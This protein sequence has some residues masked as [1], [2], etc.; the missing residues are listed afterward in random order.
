V[1][2]VLAEGLGRID[3]Q[4][5][6]V[7]V[8]I[9][10][11][12][13]SAPVA[14]LFKLLNEIVGSTAQ[15]LDYM[16]ALGTHPVMDDA[17]LSRLVGVEVVGGITGSHRVM[18]HRW[19]LPETFAT[20]GKITAQEVHEISQGR[21][22][23]EV[24]VRINKAVLEYDQLLVC[25]PVFPHEVMGFSGGNKY[26]FPGIS[27]PE[28]INVTHWV[29]AL[30]TSMNTIGVPDTPVRGLVDKAAAFIT[31]SSSCISLAMHGRD[32][33]GI[34]TGTMKGA[35]RAAAEFSAKLDI[36]YVEKPFRR[37]LSILPEIYDDIWTGAKGMYKLEPAIADGGEV[38]I[39]APHITEISYTHGRLLDQVGY[40][41]LEYFLAQWD[42]FKDVPWGILAHSTHLRGTGRYQ[43]GIETPRIKVTLATG[44]PAQRC[45]KVGLGY[46]DPA[47]INVKD[48]EG[49][50][51]QGIKVIHRAG[52][53]LYRLKA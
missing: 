39:Y 34:F 21:L 40:H 41:V 9:P 52:E 35:W 12:T 6:R 38:V 27:G 42:K 50:E 29:G 31:T 28:M 5:R 8:I 51:A 26:F 11:S 19:D 48:W 36:V 10:D 45:Q 47:T 37:V 24:P 32:L 20:I 17:A 46:I 33:R 7:L 25:G 18:N 4:N 23:L 14:M 2:N 22:S 53:I 49:K 15:G 43:N 44:I 16:V 1:R 30:I 3:L 13:R